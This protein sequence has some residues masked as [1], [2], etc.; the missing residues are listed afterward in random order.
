M[1]WHAVWLGLVL[2]VGT[3]TLEAQIMTMERDHRTKVSVTPEVASPSD[4]ISVEVSRWMSTMGGQVVGSTLQVYGRTI[5]LD[6][7]WRS[8]LLQAFGWNNHT[9]SI[10]TYDPGRYTVIVT[11]DGTDVAYAS[12]TVVGNTPGPDPFGWRRMDRFVGDPGY[13]VPTPGSLFDLLLGLHIP[14]M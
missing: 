8:G 1:K 9:E 7:Q 3:T 10:G 13:L 5:R 11:S 4:V 12:F 14:S 6:L 2:A